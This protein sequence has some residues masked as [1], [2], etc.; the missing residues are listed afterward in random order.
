M[1]DRS[2]DAADEDAASPGS[3]GATA[4]NGEAAKP[5]LGVMRS[6]RRSIRRAAESSP[7][8]PGRKGSKVTR[9]ADAAGD[10]PGSRPPP[11]PSPSAGSPV[12]SPLKNI[13]SFFQ[14]REDDEGEVTSP[15]GKPLKRSKTDPNMSASSDS[16][17]RRSFRRSLKLGTK[18]DKDRGGRQEQLVPVSE[19]S[20]EDRAEE[21]EAEAAEEE[22]EEVEE[23][24]TLPELPHT[25]LSVMQISKL[26]DMEVLEEAHL[27]LLAL[28]QELRHEMERCGDDSPIDLVKKEKDLNLLYGDLRKKVNA[29]VRDANSLPSRNKGLL[30]PVARIIQ[31]EERRA[32]ELGGLPDS[33]TE[34]W[35]EAVGEG[36]RAKVAGVHLEPKEQNASWLAVHLGLL[37]KA[38]VEDLEGVRRELRWSYPPSFRVFSTYVR[39]YHRVVGQHLKRLE[40]Q[41]TE[42]KDLY[43]L[44]D[45][46]INRYK[47]ERIMGS[48]S[49]QP[50]MRDERSDLQLEGNFLQQLKEKYCCRVKVDMRS[51]L[52]RITELENEEFWMQSKP[53][54]KEEE[55]LVSPIHMDIWTKVKG[56]AVN[57]G[58]ID[59]ELEQRVV[60]SCLQE[61]KLFPRRFEAELRRHCSALKPQAPWTEYQMTYINSFT[62]LQQHMEGYL[63]ACPGEV[64][65][66]RR[67]VEWLSVRLMQGLEE[68]FKDDVKPY[69]RRMMTRK[70]LTDDEDFDRLHSRARLLSHHCSLMRPQ[71]VQEFASHL[72]YHVAREYIGQLMKNNY[73]CKNRKHEKAA[74]KI[75]RQ[76]AKLVEVFEDMVSSHKWLYPVGD[77]LSD[78]IGQKNKTDIKN[79]LEPVVKHYP[80][81]SR[82]HLVAVL[83]FRGLMRGREHQLILQRFAELKK[84]P[85]GGSG[86]KSQ[87]LFGDMQVTVNTDCLS[88]L[89]FSCL[90]DL[91]PDS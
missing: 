57:S 72:Y 36:A 59:A 86:D 25:P 28:R 5:T 23:A 88:N 20:R 46:I 24:Y 9:G 89:T 22:M 80:D 74:A 56:N 87:V 29:I 66:F 85:G 51:S 10:E 42:L 2:T 3:D 45:W 34:A 82:K 27:N 91:L 78:I 18:K 50:D 69:L 54:E 62:A 19:G 52:D 26:I 68:Q 40:Q 73:S 84:K 48:P 33:W 14:R 49:L 55:L 76:W 39:S 17:M 1:T 16:F 7:L 61:L 53:P 4:T 63:S 58:Q 37:G 64:E 81:F 75:R 6:F 60:A 31:E 44:L 65:D 32:G 79:H 43:A 15:R 77:D 90:S 83:S 38:I 12:P 67:E 30:V 70:W 35:R 8:L 41:V 47:S 13:G 11:S 71:H 21:Q